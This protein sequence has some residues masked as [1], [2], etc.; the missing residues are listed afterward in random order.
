MTSVS[1]Y[2]VDWL[3]LRSDYAID[4]SEY[5]LSLCVR[6]CRPLLFTFDLDI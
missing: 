5:S 2:I 3:T 6:V 1:S 4:L